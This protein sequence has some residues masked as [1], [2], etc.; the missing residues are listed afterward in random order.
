MT[1]LLAQELLNRTKRIRCEMKKSD[2]QNELH[3]AQNMLDNARKRYTELSISLPSGHAKRVSASESVKDYE[4][5]VA[6][7]ENQLAGYK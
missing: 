6:Y 5:D 1:A 2:I 4:R 3:I 7:L